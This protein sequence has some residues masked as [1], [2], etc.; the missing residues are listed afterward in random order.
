MDYV[1]DYIKK[2]YDLNFVKYWDKV[3]SEYKDERFDNRVWF[4]GPTSYVFSISGTHFALDPQI[5][6]ECDFEKL[7]DNLAEY[8]S[9]IEF[10]LITHQHDDHMCIP[11]MRELKDSP[12][13]WY[14]PEGTHEDLIAKT[15]LAPEKI[16][17]VRSGDSFKIGSITVKAFKSTH[18]RPGEKEVFE[19]LGYEIATPCGKLLFPADVRNYDP[20]LYPEF[21]DIDICFAHLWAGD[22]TVNAEKYKPL[23]LEFADFYSGIGA[24]K[25]F[26]CHLYEIARDLYHM[27]RYTHAAEAMEIFMGKIPTSE[28]VIPHLGTSYSLI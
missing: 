26:I 8:T 23:L 3:F 21:S 27:W 5:R 28:V 12:I 14:I 6:R 16:V 25:Y 24:K 1:K 9:K 22:D 11:L 2:D 19:Q 20:G 15:E 17:R 4:A 13:I 10:V 18:E 7:R